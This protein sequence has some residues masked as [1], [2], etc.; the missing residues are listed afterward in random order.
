MGSLPIPDSRFAHLDEYPMDEAFMIMRDF[1]LDAHPH[2]I[3][4][5]A[6]VYRDNEAKPWILPSVREAEQLIVQDPN[7]DHE[8]QPMAGHPPFIPLAQELTFGPLM[9]SLSNRIVSCQTI[10][11]T[12][13]CHF[14]F[15][16]ISEV[17]SAKRVWISNPTWG[18]HHLLWDI[19]APQ[20]KQQLYP[21][22]NA[23]TCSL[24]F[25]AMIQTLDAEAQPGDIILLH[26]CAHNPT[27]IDPTPEQWAVIA[28]VCE[29]KQLFPLFD[30]AYQGFASG[31]LDQDAYAIRLFAERGFELAVAQSFS[32]N[33]G[34]YGQRVGA[35]HIVV[36]RSD[37][38]PSTQSHLTKLVRGEFS[39]A[40][41]HGARIVSRILSD[42][43][44]RKQWYGDLQVM[45][46]R[47]KDMR[48]ALYD[49][50]RR[51]G[52]PGSWEHIVDQIGMFSYTGLNE[53]QVRRLRD[54]QHMYMMSSGRASIAGL[55]TSNVAA[56]AAAIDAVVRA[57]KQA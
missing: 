1:A 33:F 46:S 43:A 10:S 23:K 55:N 30:S 45:S 8:Y 5:G 4:L 37:A 35:L 42:A 48:R 32:K 17:T 22:Y 16:F 6:G 26:A 13:A 41:V 12:G 39:T 24:D 31:D 29:R 51:L 14:A 19:S 57:E 2:K 21:Y 25:E 18:N 49:E 3:S 20:V 56:A 52:T 28:D 36:S 47:L 15:R 54:E 11:G 53:K 9:A 44:L 27:G 50:L 34:L 38:V 7:T 40:P